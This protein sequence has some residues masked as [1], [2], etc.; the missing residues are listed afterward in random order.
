MWTRKSDEEILAYVERQEAKRRSFLRP[1]VFALALTA[2][3]TFLY[4]AGYRGGWLRGGMVWVSGP[5]GF[6]PRTLF[7]AAFFFSFIFALAVYNQRRPGASPLSA[8]DVLLCREC[9]QPSHAGASRACG[10]GGELEP[11]AFFYWVEP[12]GSPA[13]A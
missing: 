5:E 2:V 6:G 12:E 3:A 9:R 13:E 8:G 7:T 4:S 11:F 1:L 10:C